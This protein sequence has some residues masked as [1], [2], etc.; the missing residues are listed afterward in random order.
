MNSNN[1]PTATA[2]V[3]VHCQLLPEI[4]T[5]AQTAKIGALI[6]T[7]RPITTI[8]WICVISFVERVIK[9]AVE[10]LLISAIENDSTLL[11]S[12]ERKRAV[13]D[14][15]MR[16]AKKPTTNDATKLPNAQR[17]IKPPASQIWLIVLPSVCT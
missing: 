7:C 2:V 5:I 11:N 4:F 15:A 1:A 3:V 10:N 17:S 9:L 12:I 8:V 16:A 14:A 6:S 13:N